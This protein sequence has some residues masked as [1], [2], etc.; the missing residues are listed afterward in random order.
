MFPAYADG[1]LSLPV[2]ER[3]IELALDV[4]DAGVHDLALVDRLESDACAS[5]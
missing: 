2:D 4:V 3:A 1:E 5:G